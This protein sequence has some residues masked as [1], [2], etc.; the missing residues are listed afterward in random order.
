MLPAERVE[1]GPREVFEAGPV[2]ILRVIEQPERAHH[3]VRLHALTVL[4]IDGVG[5]RALVPDRIA[6]GGAEAEVR[7]QIEIVQHLL[8]VGLQL[9]LLGVGACP[10]VALE[11]V[12]VEMRGDVD[13]GPRVAVVPPG[14]PGPFG[15]L[16]NG[17]GVDARSLEL[18]GCGDAGES[19]ADDGDLGRPGRPEV[20]ARP[21]GPH[22]RSD[23]AA[24]G[25]EDDPSAVRRCSIASVMAAAPVGIIAP[26][27][28]NPC[29]CPS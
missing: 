10:V 15:L 20:L 8:Q 4:E 1:F 6:D 25:L 28:R 21:F 19:A 13:F 23:P 12:R 18:D 22:A 27:V 7:A 24:A 11:R 9:G 16:E 3:H 2:R 29:I 14:T 17:E 26:M 5:V